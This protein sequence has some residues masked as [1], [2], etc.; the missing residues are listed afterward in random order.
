[1]RVGVGRCVRGRGGVGGFV[2][3]LACTLL[4]GDLRIERE[5]VKCKARMDGIWGGDGCDMW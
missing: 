3:H 2:L 4:K 5:W 1:M